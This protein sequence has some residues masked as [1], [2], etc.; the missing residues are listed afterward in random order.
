[1]TTSDTRRTNPTPSTMVMD[2]KRRLIVASTPAFGSGA[3]SQI[4]FNDSWSCPNG[5]DALQINVASPMIA[6]RVPMPVS[7][8]F[9]TPCPRSSPGTSL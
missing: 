7:C 2:R 8:E 9:A 6:E 5:L 1:M 3:T 4:V